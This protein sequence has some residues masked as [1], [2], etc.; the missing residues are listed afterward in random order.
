MNA[1]VLYECFKH[2]ICL[3]MVDC[4]KCRV[5]LK[6]EGMLMANSTTSFDPGLYPSLQDAPP[7]AVVLY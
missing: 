4:L 6:H 3:K 1:P 7:E 2:D 5:E